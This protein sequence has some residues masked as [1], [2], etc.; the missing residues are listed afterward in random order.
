M[1]LID[2]HADAAPYETR[3]RAVRRPA[4]T[5]LLLAL[6][7]IMIVMDVVRRRRRTAGSGSIVA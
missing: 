4:L 6:I 7:A 1:T 5:T 2:L 3:S